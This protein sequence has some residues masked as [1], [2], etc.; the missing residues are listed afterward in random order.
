MTSLYALILI[1]YMQPAPSLDARVARFDVVNAPQVSLEACNQSGQSLVG[2]IA[3]ETDSNVK[4]TWQ[5]FKCVS[6]E[7]K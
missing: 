6:L 2:P 3:A 4:Y 5:D 7:N 1:V